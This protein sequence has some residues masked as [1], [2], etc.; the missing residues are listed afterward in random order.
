MAI[1]DVEITRLS[2]HPLN[3]KFFGEVAVVDRSALKADIKNNGIKV[4]L[5][6]TPD[7]QILA[8]ATRFRI[9]QELGI[10]KLPCQIIQGLD[11]EDQVSAYIIKDNLLRRHLATSDRLLLFSELSF[12]N[13]RGRGI[14][15][16]DQ[17]RESG[18]FAPKDAQSASLGKEDDVLEKTAKEVGVSPRTIAKARQYTKKIQEH[19]ELKNAPVADVLKLPT[20]QVLK[21]L[22]EQEEEDRRTKPPEILKLSYNKETD[23]LYVFKRKGT[24]I[25]KGLGNILISFDSNQE[26]VGV[27]IGKFKDLLAAAE[28]IGKVDLSPQLRE[29]TGMEG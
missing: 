10:K 15:T 7:Y 13:E 3:D 27:R 29:N 9:A 12:M 5:Q 11:T 2:V 26:V 28:R 14:A 22:H 24:G 18:K 19:P 17:P 6:I 20:K 8:G 4:A 1:E 21:E 23:S 25:A 16:K